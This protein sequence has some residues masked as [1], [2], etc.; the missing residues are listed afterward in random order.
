MKLF[1][2]L[3]AGLLLTVGACNMSS[4]KPKEEAKPAKME[5]PTQPADQTP[6]PAAETPAEQAPVQQ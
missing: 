2:L 6:A 4:E 3:C 1:S 5:E